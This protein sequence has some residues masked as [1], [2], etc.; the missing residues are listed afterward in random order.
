MISVT[1][2]ACTRPPRVND[3]KVREFRE[4]LRL[5]GLRPEYADEDSTRGC[6]PC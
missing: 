2:N 1:T 6:S 5:A 3:D 4:L